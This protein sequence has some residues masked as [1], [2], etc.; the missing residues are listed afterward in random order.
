MKHDSRNSMRVEVRCSRD[1]GRRRDIPRTFPVRSATRPRAFVRDECLFE[2][3]MP[4]RRH[5]RSLLLLQWKPKPWY[6]TSRMSERDASRGHD[7]CRLRGK[8]QSEFALYA[9]SDWLRRLQLVR[10]PI[11]A[12]RHMRAYSD[13][14]SVIA[15]RKG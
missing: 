13:L 4:D 8:C 6:S 14:L 11:H 2:R 7:G 9:D 1:S 3:G 15:I 10:G 5:S 12:I